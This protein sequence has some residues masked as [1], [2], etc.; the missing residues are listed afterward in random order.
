VKIIP[1]GRQ[2]IDE[3]DIEA[4]IEVLKGDYL[5]T[6]PYI[7]EFEKNFAQKVGAKH[8]VAVSSGTAA[9]HLACLAAGLKEGDEV[10]TTPMTFAATAN[11][12]LFTG[13][14]PVFADIDPLTGNID[15]Q[16]IENRITE[17]TKAIIPVHY[18]GLPCEMEEISGIARKNGI[19]IIEDACHALG[20]CCKGTVIGD[21]TYSDM[22][23]F[24]FHPV[25]HITTGEGGII[26][27]NSEELYKRLAF[28]RSHGIVRDGG[29]L[30]G[31]SHGGWYYEMQYLGFNYRMT[32]IQAALGISQLKKLEWFIERRR[33]IAGMYNRNLKDLS[34]ELP[35]EP[36]GYSSSYHLYTIRLKKEAGITR[37]QLY[38]RL[39][40]K[41]IYTQVHYIPVH[42]FPYYQDKLGYR[43]GD[44]PAAEHHYSRVLSL[45]IFPGM[46]DEEV[47]RV[48]DAVKEVIK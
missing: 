6:G 25:K 23:V 27:T 33:E 35:V 47:Q 14:R 10:I 21:C 20:A 41:N 5:T 46:T 7:E 12:A 24:S 28:L 3:S 32:D 13:A 40:E 48:I 2:H 1:Y 29:D 44:Y 17:C 8:A 9:L 38:D 19:T 18:T 30:K 36:E 15:P 34:L 42:T 4:V 39:R 43:W 22:T 37:K 11:S 45:P 31:K 16:E 26:T